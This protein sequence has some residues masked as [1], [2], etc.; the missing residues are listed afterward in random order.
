[1]AETT[2]DKTNF[3]VCAAYAL[4]ELGRITRNA[5]DLQAQIE[6]LQRDLTRW[7]TQW[8]TEAKHD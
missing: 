4:E 3:V 6:H 7:E 5:Q 1:M 8:K 2:L